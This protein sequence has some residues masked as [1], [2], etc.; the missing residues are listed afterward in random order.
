VAQRIIPGTREMWHALRDGAVWMAIPLLV[1]GL[2]QALSAL[3]LATAIFCPPFRVA[4][5]A[6]RR[7]RRAL[8]ALYL[9]MVAALFIASYCLIHLEMRLALPTVPLILLPFGWS[10]EP[11]WQ[12]CRIRLQRASRVNGPAETRMELR[13][14]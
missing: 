13:R 3:G 10:I 12:R 7:D 14:L 4:G 11:W 6:L 5:T 9:W 1:V 2:L 8:V